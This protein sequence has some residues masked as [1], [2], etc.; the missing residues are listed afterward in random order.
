MASLT[1]TTYNVA[2]TKLVQAYKNT[3][4]PGRKNSLASAYKA[5]DLFIHKFN[6]DPDNVEKT[7]NY[8]Y[9]D[10]HRVIYLDLDYCGTAVLV[11]IKD[12]WVFQANDDGTREF[13]DIVSGKEYKDIS[14]QEAWRKLW[15][16]SHTFVADNGTA[17]TEESKHFGSNLKIRVHEARDTTA[18][19]LIQTLK[20][21]A[22]EAQGFADNLADPKFREDDTS[23]DHVISAAR[24]FLTDPVHLGKRR[25]FFSMNK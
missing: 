19:N 16:V 3:N 15:E 18:D 12:Y 20:A 13:D 25:S 9:Y 21:V 7:V 8:H 10:K 22:A 11:G 24:H 6:I 2:Y 4:D 14:E 17:P 5:L 23:M 1:F